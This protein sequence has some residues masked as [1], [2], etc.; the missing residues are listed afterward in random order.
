VK[1]KSFL[2]TAGPTQEPIDPVR[3][4]SNKSTGKMGYELAEQAIKRGH[5]VVLVSGPTALKK[6]QKAQFVE[7]QTAKQMLRAV[8]K[9]IN[10]VDCIIMSAAVA[11]MTPKKVAKDKIKK[12][13]VS[14]IELVQSKDILESLIKIKTKYKVGFSL[15]TQKSIENS[16]NKMIKKELDLIVVNK[17]SRVNDPFGQGLKNITLL[18]REGKRK[19]IR[20]N[21]KKQIAGAILDT[22]LGNML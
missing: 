20:Q 7:V 3:F 6:P 22:I 2:I 10:N 19:N 11:D 1:K 4:I 21:S 16:K 13:Q 18:D 17:V 12:G 9:H 14:K 5:K 8:K 15:E